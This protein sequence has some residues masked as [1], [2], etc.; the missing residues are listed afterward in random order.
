VD[1]LPPTPTQPDR[2]ERRISTLATFFAGALRAKVRVDF[3]GLLGEPRK[4]DPG[5]V[6]SATERVPAHARKTDG[7]PV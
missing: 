4:H 2:E 5:A 7:A 1:Q 6:M 3:D